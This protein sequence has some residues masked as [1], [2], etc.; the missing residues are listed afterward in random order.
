[1]NFLIHPL[2]T[3]RNRKTIN[4]TK[5]TLDDDKGPVRILFRS[6][7]REDPFFILFEA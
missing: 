5:V 2:G 1:M 7:S 4:V 6:L 3:E